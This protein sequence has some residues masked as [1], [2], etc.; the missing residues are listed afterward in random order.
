[1][2]FLYLK[3]SDPKTSFFVTNPYKYSCK[4]G[5]GTCSCT[6]KNVNFR[7]SAFC[8][9]WDHP[10][11]HFWQKW[12][13]WYLHFQESHFWYW[14]HMSRAFV[15]TLF[16]YFYGAVCDCSNNVVTTKQTEL[17]NHGESGGI[18]IFHNLV[19]NRKN[20]LVHCQ[21]A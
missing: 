3:W 15:M 18:H 13:I 14:E 10:G 8:I 6:S 7:C 5:M 1:M 2:L 16:F 19:C 11:W 9:Y 12:H 20:L 17:A 4:I 21:N